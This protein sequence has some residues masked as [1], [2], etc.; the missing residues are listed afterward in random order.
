MELIGE[1]EKAPKMGQYVST[2]RRWRPEFEIRLQVRFFNKAGNDPWRGSVFR[3]ASASTPFP[4]PNEPGA[5]VLSMMVYGRTSPF[6]LVIIASIN[7]K[8]EEFYTELG[9]F[10]VMRYYYVRIKQEQKV[11]SS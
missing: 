5:T 6:K 7:N 9:D 3:F 2:I 11:I 10:S 1:S 4:D 8:L